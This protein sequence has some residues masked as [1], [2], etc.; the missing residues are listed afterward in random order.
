MLIMGWIPGYGSLLK[1]LIIID[2]KLERK[3][4]PSITLMKTQEINILISSKFKKGK[5]TH[6]T[7]TTTT[8][9]A[10]TTATTS[11]NNNKTKQELAITGHWYLSISMN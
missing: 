6:T 2:G 11:I 10:T 7:T 1:L 4:I 5:C 9:T 8:T 3:P